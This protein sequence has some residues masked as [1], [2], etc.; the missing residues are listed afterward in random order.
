MAPEIHDVAAGKRKSYDEKVDVWALGVVTQEACIMESP[1]NSINHATVRAMV[2]ECKLEFCHS[3]W[4]RF[5]DSGAI[6]LI[7]EC[8]TVDP[9]C[10]RSAADLFLKDQFLQ[11]GKIEEGKI[12]R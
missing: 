9:T 11:L 2:L 12:A 3:G 7:R 1:F 8:L 5:K 4:K 10:R 6:E